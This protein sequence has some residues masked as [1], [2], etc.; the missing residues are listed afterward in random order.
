[1]STIMSTP[2]V[3]ESVDVKLL[4]L[5]D[6]LTG[7]RLT[8]PSVE[9]E[10]TITAP[11]GVDPDT[12]P[13]D[14]DVDQHGNPFWWATFVPLVAGEHLVKTHAEYNGLV[15]RHRQIVEVEPW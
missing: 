14:E 6:G 13:P 3:G 5:I 2:H 8:G 1:M 15:F 12:S 9:V 10:V 4:D 11:S 7:D